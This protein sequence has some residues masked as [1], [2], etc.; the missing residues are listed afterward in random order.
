MGET[1]DWSYYEDRL[2]I[3]WHKQLH[4]FEI[5]FY[6]IEYGISQI[7]ALQT[8]RNVLQNKEEGIK[9][10]ENYLS[11]GYTRSIPETYEAGSIKF[12]F[13]GSDVEALFELLTGK[14]KELGIEF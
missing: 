4:I 13:S 2:Q 7:G 3:A 14:I 9:G 12:W 10:F 1:L 8:W 6:Y 11:L 5:P